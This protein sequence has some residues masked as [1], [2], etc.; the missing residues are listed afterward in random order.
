MSPSIQEQ[1]FVVCIQVQYFECAVEHRR[2]IIMTTSIVLCCV[3]LGDIIHPIFDV[4]MLCVFVTSVV[5][6]ICLCGDLVFLTS[7]MFLFAVVLGDDSLL[8]GKYVF[9]FRK[10]RLAIGNYIFYLPMTC[11]CLTMACMCLEMK[12]FSFGNDNSVPK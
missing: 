12:C 6:L 8:F 1:S 7:Q 4:L 10:E 3:F 9:L 5:C 11:F 2:T